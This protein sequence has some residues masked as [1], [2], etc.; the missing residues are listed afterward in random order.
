M[1]KDSHQRAAEFHEL[2]AHAHRAAAVHHGKEAH[3]TAHEHSKEAREYSNKAHQRSEEAIKKSANTAV[4]VA[5]PR[6]FGPPCLGIGP[7]L[8]RSREQDF[9]FY[10]EFPGGDEAVKINGCVRKRTDIG[11]Q[12]IQC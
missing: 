1:P 2:A 3:Q 11:G 7:S 6:N 12:T 10:A 9:L 5:H 8:A 4:E